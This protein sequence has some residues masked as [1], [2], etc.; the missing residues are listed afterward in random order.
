MSGQEIIDAIYGERSRE[1]TDAKSKTY[2]VYFKKSTRA[3]QK[4]V[5][6]RS[7]KEHACAL[8]ALYREQ[9]PNTAQSHAPLFT[10]IL[11]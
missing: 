9:T 8:K 7:E 10:P 1:A 11:T 2:P 6:D 4:S 3:V 5:R